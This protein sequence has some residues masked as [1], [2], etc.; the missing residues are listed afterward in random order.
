VHR[1]LDLALRVA[2]PVLALM[3]LV[4]IALAYLSRALGGRSLA[5]LESPLRAAMCV[6]V[7]AL[8][9]SP[10]AAMAADGL[11]SLLETVP[12]QLMERRNV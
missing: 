10:V 12:L 4:T 11:Q 9:L 1:S 5:S 2:A 3:S 6:A 8:S 7:L